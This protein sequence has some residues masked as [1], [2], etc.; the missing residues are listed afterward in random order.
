MFVTKEGG[1][2]LFGNDDVT[3]RIGRYSSMSRDELMR[4]LEHEAAA[5]RAQG[6]LD[7]AKL[8]EFLRSAAPYMTADQIARM[9]ELIDALR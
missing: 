2:D 4:E 6:M 5:L 8:E 9:R 1:M 7:M 3:R